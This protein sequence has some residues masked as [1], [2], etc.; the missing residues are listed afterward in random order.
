MEREGVAE[1]GGSYSG[2]SESWRA[3][4]LRKDSAGDIPHLAPDV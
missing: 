4:W 3:A 2:N 1:G